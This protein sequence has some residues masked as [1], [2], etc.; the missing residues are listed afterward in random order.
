MANKRRIQYPGMVTHV[1]SRGNEK[2]KIFKDDPDR[3]KFLQIIKD[4][5]KDYNYTLH[6]YTLMPNHYH[7]LIETHDGQLSKLM[8]YING[9]YSI[10]FNWRHKRTGHL[11][12][13][14]FKNTVLEKDVNLINVTRY[15][16]LNPLKDGL[17]ESLSLYGWSSYR[18]YLGRKGFGITDT[19]WVIG[20]FDKD[21][22]TAL[23]RMKMHLAEKDSMD[24]KAFEENP[25]SEILY[26]STGFLKKIQK[27]LSRKGILVPKKTYKIDTIEP[28]K[29]LS[30]VARE[31]KTNK[32]SILYK[33]GKFNY[34]KKAAIYYV[35]KHTSMNVNEIA[36][37]FKIHYSR[38][39]RNISSLLE[40]RK[41]N[42]ILNQKLTSIQQSF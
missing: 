12:Q 32:K 6:A 15:I 29:I 39:S 21:R 14:R 8:K 16:H 7:L 5:F 36:A 20:W 35:K 34:G 27:K 1:Y 18:E 38:I 9:K 30:I 13:G 25:G 23:K 22:K 37:L 3:I 26:S 31:F 42:D 10:Y 40:E 2:K 19:T 11:F 24:Y 28:E 4:S 33:K 41:I 17:T